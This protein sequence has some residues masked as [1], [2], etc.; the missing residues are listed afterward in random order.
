ML[1]LH[2]KQ[3]YVGKGRERAKIKIFFPFC[4]YPTGNR[5]FEKKRKKIKKSKNTIVDSFQAK[6]GRKRPRN[7]EKKI[8]VPFRSH[9]TRNRK[10]QKN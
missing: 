3:K 4:S 7:G 5:K 2:F 1:L 6:I 9:S 10:F 8:A